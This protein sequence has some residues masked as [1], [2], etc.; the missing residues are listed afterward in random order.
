MSDL[1]VGIVALL[2]TD[3]EA[4]TRLVQELGDDYSAVMADHRRLIR[5][6]VEQFGGHEIDCRGD[7]FFV[8]FDST[9]DAVHA[10]AGA[11][12]A[13]AGH[14][15]PSEAPLR[16]R[17]GVH[18][19]E[20]TPAEGG[21]VGLDVHRAARI[22]AAG[23]GGQVLVSQSAHDLLASL[24]EAEFRDL[25]EYELKGLPRPERLYQLVAEG[26]H[27]E[28]PAL[29]D[30]RRRRALAGRGGDARRPRRGLRPPARGDRPAALRRRIPGRRPAID[31][32][33]PAA[34]S[35][36][37]RPAGRDHRHPHAADADRRGPARGAA[38][39]R[40][41]SRRRRARAV[42][43]RR[44]VVR[45]GAARRERRGRRLPAEGSRRRRRRVRRRGAP[46]RRGRLRARSRARD[47]AGRAPPARR[48]ARR[49]DAA[50]AR[51]A[52][53][54]GGGPLEPGHR[55]AP[56]RDRARGRE[57]RDEHLQQAPA[58]AGI[59]RPPAGA[60]RA[61][62]PARRA[63]EPAALRITTYGGSSGLAKR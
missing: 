61:G 19:G 50:R 55:P 30:R 59:G 21:Y 29:P 27:A 37:L 40:R 17:M 60:R 14:D 33:R 35:T 44:A 1:P 23:H 63:D 9:R 51:G 48:S 22:C 43:V 52:R 42:A 3:V 6:A 56:G 25:G 10:A 57:A 16:V 32:R 28:F 38:D 2:F 31:R 13:L 12:R 49:A 5:E 34:Q 4:S 7:E 41:A 53:A 46:G 54:D 20:P 11:Q 26:L 8:A 15:W 24:E 58:S 62:V 39:P 18:T 45:H 36:Q 47:A